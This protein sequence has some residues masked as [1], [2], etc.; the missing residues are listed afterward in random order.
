MGTG[1]ALAL[2]AAA[3]WGLAPVATKGALA[4]YSPEVIGVIR[5]AVAAVLLRRLGKATGSWL[6]TDRWSWIGGVALGVDFILYNYGLRLTSAGVSGLV[7]NVEVVSTIVLAVWLLGEQLTARRISGSVVTLGG[8]LFVSSAGLSLNDLAAREHLLGNVLVMVA[9]ISWSVFAVAQRQAPRHDNLFQMLA[10][11]FAVA[12][13]TTAPPLLLPSAWHNP[14]GGIPTLM[15]GALVV[16]CTVAVYLVYARCQELVD[17]SV[18]A[19]IIGTIPIFALV[20]AL[21]ILGEPFSSRVVVG[22][23]VVLAGVLVISTERPATGALEATAV[24]RVP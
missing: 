23:A 18:L 4:G 17:V 16:L 5:L 20:L 8:V 14:G 11:I 19:V 13:L 7:I 22:G 6:P 9:G 2:L 15:V 21:L 10:P 1:I 3:L 24:E 12:A